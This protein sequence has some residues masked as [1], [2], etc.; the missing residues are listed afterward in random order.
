MQSDPTTAEVK[1]FSTDSNAWIV[2]TPGRA[3]PALVVQG[4]TFASFCHMAESILER[5]RSC[6]CSDPELVDEA[7]E[8]VEL[9][10]A[11]LNHYETVLEQA[12]FERPLNPN[13]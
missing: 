6:D 13:G 3:Y 10:R 1:V 4:D 9:L 7:D 5:A 8:L 11:R 12:G 2:Q